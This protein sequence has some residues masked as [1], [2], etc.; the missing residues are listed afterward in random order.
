MVIPVVAVAIAVVGVFTFS[1]ARA[2]S[3][4]D[5]DNYDLPQQGD[6]GRR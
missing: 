5:P 4:A 3:W 2:A 1:L 6:R